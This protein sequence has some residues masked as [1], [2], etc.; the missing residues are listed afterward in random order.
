MPTLLFWPD[1]VCLPYLP[2]LNLWQLI[3]DLLTVAPFCS[4]GLE[5]RDNKPM[6][7][8]QGSVE[9]SDLF[10]P[11]DLF[12]FDD[13]ENKR[14]DESVD[15]EVT[16]STNLSTISQSDTDTDSVVSEVIDNL[17]QVYRVAHNIHSFVIK[18]QRLY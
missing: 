17:P 14:D 9:L 4:R 5:P 18:Y 16:Q 7:Q 2:S 11:D 13:N 12:T 15:T 6:P 3:T 10:S 1:K 8:L